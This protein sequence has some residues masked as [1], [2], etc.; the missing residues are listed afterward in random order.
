MNI[1]KLQNICV[2]I[3]KLKQQLVEELPHSSN[4]ALYFQ[5]NEITT[6]IINDRTEIKM[7]LI[8]GQILYFSD[9][10]GDFIDLEKDNIS[11]K[12]QSIA[13]D[14]KLELSDSK[15]ENPTSD[16]MKSFL[17]YAELA[18][19]I[20]ENFRMKMQAKNFTRVHLWPH[21]FDFSVE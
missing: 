18:V 5:N 19:K 2:E 4:Q 11:E 21:H 6:G 9:E 14:H 12:L 20:L 15:L 17:Q 10:K 13:K 1:K 7:H 16:E 8:S 3:S